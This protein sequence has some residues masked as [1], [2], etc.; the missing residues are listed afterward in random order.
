MPLS[1]DTKDKDVMSNSSYGCTGV[2]K[3]KVTFSRIATNISA[4]CHTNITYAQFFELISLMLG[5][6]FSQGRAIAQVVSHRLPN[7]AAWVRF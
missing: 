5:L 7:S 2:R 1:E 4:R 3:F 6:E